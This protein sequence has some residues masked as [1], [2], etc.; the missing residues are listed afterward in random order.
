MEGKGERRK[1]R[2]GRERIELRDGRKWTENSRLDLTLFGQ[3]GLILLADVIG[4]LDI[5]G[6][7]R[8]ADDLGFLG[9][10]LT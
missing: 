8:F 2:F 10:G 9:W 3:D 5:R 6:A 1:G 4:D 7:I